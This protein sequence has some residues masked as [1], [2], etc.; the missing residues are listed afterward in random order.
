MVNADGFSYEDS[1]ETYGSCSVVFENRMLVFGAD[2]GSDAKQKQITEVKSCSLQKIGELPF[3]FNNGACGTY[4][5]STTRVFLCFPSDGR[6]CWQFYE[7]F[8]LEAA[9]STFKHVFTSLGIYNGNPVGISG[10]DTNEV[11]MYL[12]NK[13]ESLPP[14]SDITRVHEFSTITRGGIMYVF[15]GADSYTYQTA[16]WEF[17]GQWKL[18]VSLLLARTGHRSMLVNDTIIHIGGRSEES[19]SM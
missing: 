12:N 19:D 7:S 15:G 16:V 10:Y 4:D 18:G 6:S 17:N 2:S 1:T 9:S 14:L 13:W 8:V 5:F 3:K 11:E